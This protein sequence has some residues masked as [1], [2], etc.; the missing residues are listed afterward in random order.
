MGQCQSTDVGA[1]T[2]LEEKSQRRADSA[3]SLR[4]LAPSREPAP[5]LPLIRC[6]RRPRP[7]AAWSADPRLA[8]A[9]S[10][11]ETCEFAPFERREPSHLFREKQQPPPEQSRQGS[12]R[13]QACAARSC[14]KLRCWITHLLHP[15]LKSALSSWNRH[16]LKSLGM[17]LGGSE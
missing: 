9:G 5:E 16:C 13:S 2:L 11:G 3:L 4:G 6:R 17:P 10:R 8:P 1:D 15:R 7:L 14:L 12:G